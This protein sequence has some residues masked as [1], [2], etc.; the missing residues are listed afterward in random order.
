MRQCATSLL[1]LAAISFVAA[2][3]AGKAKVERIT[4]HVL[5]ER[6]EA[7]AVALEEQLAGK[8][9]DLFGPVSKVSRA[10]DDLRCVELAAYPKGFL[11]R[12]RIPC[13]FG[14][15]HRLADLEGN[16]PATIRGTLKI[17]KKGPELHNCS[18]P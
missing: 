13:Y 1:L 18:R 14:K 12:Y 15:G 7:N 4:T 6:Y 8:T 10:S 11:S 3:Q 16:K 9:I 2:G 17:G 5:M